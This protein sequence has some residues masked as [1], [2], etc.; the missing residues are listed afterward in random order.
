MIDY[1]Q[2]LGVKRTASMREI[3][4]AY[5]RLARKH[6]PDVNREDQSPARDFAQIALAYR[7][8]SNPDERERYDKQRQNMAWQSGSSVMNSNNPHARRMRRAA[9]QRRWDAAVDRWMEAERRE[10][11]H[12]TQAVF[13][14]VSLFLSIFM[15]ALFKPRIWDAAGDIGRLIVL[16]LFVIGLCHIAL[17]IRDSFRR[18]TY[19]A[20]DASS[21]IEAEE[22]ETKPFARTT[23]S[24]FLILGYAASFGL[25]LLAS[26]YAYPALLV[27]MAFF[28]G[29]NVRPDML[30]Y[31]PI[32]V[33][34]VDTMHTV[35]TK[36]DSF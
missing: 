30:F 22:H 28:F 12:R 27:N 36:M 8:L 4:T 3:K 6:H 34:L 25:G 7:T 19:K 11:Q 31:P 23:A 2:T 16:T 21:V 10:N 1:Y 33:L 14:T 15:V 5:R 35:A 20:T 17:R 29:N 32:A 18:Y 24:A 9:V 13:T 26:K